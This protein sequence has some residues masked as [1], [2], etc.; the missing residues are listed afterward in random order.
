MPSK[1][2]HRVVLAHYSSL[3][4]VDLPNDNE[5]LEQAGLSY[6]A[7]ASRSRQQ[8]RAEIGLRPTKSQARHSQKSP[9]PAQDATTKTLRKSTS[10]LE[11]TAERPLSQKH[12]KDPPQTTIVDPL[13]TVV[14]SKAPRRRGINSRVYLSDEDD[15]EIVPSESSR[16]TNTQA[17][18]S[19]QISQQKAIP[20]PSYR[21]NRHSYTSSFGTQTPTDPI[22]KVEDQPVQKYTGPSSNGSGSRTTSDSVWSDTDPPDTP[23]TPPIR[24]I[25]GSP[26]HSFIS[27][28]H[29]QSQYDGGNRDR[30]DLAGSPRYERAETP[31]QEAQQSRN[32]SG[33]EPFSPKPLASQRRAKENQYH[34]G[35][36]HQGYDEYLST[37]ADFPGQF[38]MKRGRAHDGDQ[39]LD[40]TTP[41]SQM[42]GGSRDESKNPSAN[43]N[44]SESTPR[45]SMDTQVFNPLP[46]EP[47]FDGFG[48]DEE[49]ANTPQTVNPVISSG[50]YEAQRKENHEQRQIPD[51]T[52]PRQYSRNVQDQTQM[53]GKPQESTSVQQQ[54]KV[55]S[56]R[57][58][59]SYSSLSTLSD[60]IPSPV[61]PQRSS[62]RPTPEPAHRN[63]NH[64]L[65]M[66]S[67]ANPP[68]AVFS[69]SIFEGFEPR[70]G[71]DDHVPP[72]P[73]INLY[74]HPA[75]RHTSE[76]V[77]TAANA[78][79]PPDIP[80][81]RRFSS[82]LGNARNTLP[83]KAMDSTPRG[84]KSRDLA[85]AIA[86]AE[87][88]VK[89]LKQE[90][91]GKQSFGKKS[92]SR[93]KKFLGRTKIA[94]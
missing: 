50:S 47:D 14:K 58:H 83:P 52:Q 21:S 9:S 79:F 63:L 53:Y 61:I 81:S 73:R 76:T 65:S 59:S 86:E 13:R 16:D 77:S 10:N 93:L 23:L 45:Y 25:H 6:S 27:N 87:L 7:Y 34:L 85:R 62:H 78:L 54:A 71:P 67:L 75:A 56:P 38:T 49:A 26:R 64:S 4:L 19:S 41:T 60:F 90:A 94:D 3:G 37:G 24:A 88:K 35:T 29:S 80:T 91:A 22:T 92:G 33:K 20:P 15:T 42:A 70:G 12:P 55:H 84:D 82:P 32:K 89:T 11:R 66:S 57:S 46:G 44:I 17:D 30:L 2:S 40:S 1:Y 74:S 43:R 69:P 51:E 72:L 39:Q 36:S 18:S 48:L 5:L 28:P 31:V 8:S 68:N